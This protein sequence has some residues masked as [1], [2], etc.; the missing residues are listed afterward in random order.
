MINMINSKEVRT[1]SIPRVNSIPSIETKPLTLAPL[2]IKTSV[3]VGAIHETDSSIYELDDKT[4]GHGHIALQKF[5]VDD[6]GASSVEY[7][8]PRRKPLRTKKLYFDIDSYKMT[9]CAGGKYYR[10]TTNLLKSRDVGRV[11]VHKLIAFL[12]LG[13]NGGAIHHKNYNGKDNRASN[14]VYFPSNVAHKAYHT[15]VRRRKIDK[16]DYAA[17]GGIEITPTSVDHREDVP[18]CLKKLCKK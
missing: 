16:T 11:Y 17:Y 2:Y 6:P 18:K 12:C 1:I 9:S 15:A 5:N 4:K 10:L 14:L 7:K 13:K 8:R 3:K